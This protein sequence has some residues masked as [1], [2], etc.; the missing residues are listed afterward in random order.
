[1]Q[2]CAYQAVFQKILTLNCSLTIGTPVYRL[3]LHYINK[4]YFHQVPIHRKRLPSHDL[5]NAG[6][7]TKKE[8]DT[9]LRKS[10]RQKIQSSVVT[11]LDNK[12]VN[13][14]STFIGKHPEGEVQRFNRK[15]KYFRLCLAKAKAMLIYNRNMGG[16]DYLFQIPWL[17]IIYSWILWRKTHENYMPL[18]DFK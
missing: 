11:W 13:F 15:T 17:V 12:V 6:Q 18:L 2:P 10:Q 1:M 9:A 5:P 16:V 7:M 3:W 4:V 14:A 8:E